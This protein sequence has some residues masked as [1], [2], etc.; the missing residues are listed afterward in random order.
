MSVQSEIEHERMRFS[1]MSQSQLVTR[2]NR[3][4]KS[5][6]LLRFANMAEEQGMTRLAV[7]ARE[8][9]QRLFGHTVERASTGRRSS[10]IP[11]GNSRI[12]REDV[13][14]A[15]SD[16]V[17]RLR[18]SRPNTVVSSEPHV[19]SEPE[20]KSKKKKDDKDPPKGTRVIRF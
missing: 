17:G 6:K 15:V 12:G 10:S 4:T 2:L 1:T 20:K 14:E 8:R 19:V 18:A 16:M 9:F 5:D 3:I 7:Q 13:L 11:T